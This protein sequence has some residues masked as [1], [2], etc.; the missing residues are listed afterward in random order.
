MFQTKIGSKIL[1]VSHKRIEKPTQSVYY[2]HI[3]NH[4]EL[5]LFISG[6]ADYNIDGQIYSPA[7]YDLLFIPAA[8][9]H[10][11]IPTAAIPYE[12]YVI[13]IDPIL[14]DS[15]HYEILFNSPL[16]ISIKDDPEMF[17]FFQRLDHYRE[18]YS[19]SDF[20][21]CTACLIQELITYCAYR[22]PKL[23]HVRSD[24]IPYIDD[25]IEYINQ[26]LQSEIDAQAIANHF[27]L[28]KSYIQNI[29]SQNFKQFIKHLRNSC[30]KI[31]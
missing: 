10:Y 6:K 25:I 11:L 29:F 3:H 21:E 27:L 8:T 1:E 7:P 12:N 28:S 2:N 9:Y 24:T 23:T 18:H 14:I 20:S 19:E 26:N 30:W 17:G 13:G 16:M 22:K 15:G 4:C 31:V 5:L